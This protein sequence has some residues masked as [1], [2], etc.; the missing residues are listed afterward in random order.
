MDDCEY[1]YANGYI[2]SLAGACG[3]KNSDVLGEP[4]LPL[5]RG[6]IKTFPGWIVLKFFNLFSIPWSCKTDSSLEH[7][8]YSGRKNKE[9]SR[10]REGILSY[11]TGTKT[12]RPSVIF[13]SQFHPQQP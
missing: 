13:L 12:F 1:L 8:T 2:R 4:L 10:K 6:V 11:A 9:R 7:S 3:A 5:L